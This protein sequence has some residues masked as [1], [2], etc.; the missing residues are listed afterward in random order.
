[1]VPLL[2]TALLGISSPAQADPAPPHLEVRTPAAGYSLPRGTTGQLAALF[3]QDG[4]EI[5][6]AVAPAWVSSDPTVLAVTPAGAYTALTPGRVSVAA[7]VEGVTARLELS[8]RS[9][10]GSTPA[11]PQAKPPPIPKPAPGEVVATPGT[12]AIV[13]LLSPAEA[14]KPVVAD[15][16]GLS[17]CGALGAHHVGTVNVR[18]VVEAGGWVSVARVEST[19]LANPAAESCVTGRVSKLTFPAPVD[20]DV[21]SVSIPVVFSLSN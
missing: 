4:K 3:L 18:F 19:T 17:K 15:G 6:P 5:V 10:N 12:P 13:G 8:V 16:A 11:T 9:A 1:M 7:T 14:S 2:L 21:V 20:G